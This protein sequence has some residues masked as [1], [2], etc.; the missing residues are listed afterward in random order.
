M[1]I[2]VETK[3]CTALS[4]GDLAEMADLWLPRIVAGLGHDW[5]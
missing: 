2:E 1:A 3:D 4:D 5:I